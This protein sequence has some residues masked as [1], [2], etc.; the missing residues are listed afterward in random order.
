MYDLL[1]I[2]VIPAQ[3]GIHALPQPSQTLRPPEFLRLETLTRNA[4]RFV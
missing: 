2:S 3:A 1:G 4:S